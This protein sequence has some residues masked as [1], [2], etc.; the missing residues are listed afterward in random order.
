MKKRTP[1]ILFAVLVMNLALCR[2]MMGGLPEM[3]PVELDQE[4]IDKEWDELAAQW[5]CPEWFKD[6]KL[7]LWLH[8]GP[9]SV[10]E[11]GGGWFALHMYQSKNA[12]AFGAKAFPYFREKFGPQWKY[13]YKDV[14]NAWKAEK[15][16][17]DAIAERFKE[18]GAKYIAII[19][20]H[21]DHFDN[22]DS[23]YH[24]WNSVKVGP[25]R[26]IVGELK[27]AAD[28]HGLR[29]GLTCHDDR[30]PGFLGGSRRSEMVN[31]EKKLYDGHLTVEDGKG[32]WWE[33]LDPQNLY[34]GPGWT[35][36]KRMQHFVVRHEELLDK[37]EPDLF[38][39]DKGNFSP[40]LAGKKVAAYFYR[41][42]LERNGKI[43]AVM[44]LKSHKP[45]IVRDMEKHVASTTI[46]DYYWQIDTTYGA[47]F[48]KTDRE[49]E[50]SPET[51]IQMLVD[52]ISKNG[53]L[54][55]NVPQWPDG[56]FPEEC[57]E[58]L[59]EL[60]AWMKVN[61]SAVYGT[62]YWEVYRDGPTSFRASNRA[63]KKTDEQYASDEVR[64][65]KKDKTLY[66]FL[67]NPQ[68]GP[69][70]MKALGLKHAITKPGKVTAVSIVGGEAVEFS[71]NDEALE[72][73]VPEKRP[74][75]FVTALKI[76]GAIR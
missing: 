47:W 44:N 40:G 55:L 25:K 63:R 11:V 48:W 3:P 18:A 74:S 57:E 10:P 49:P 72:L 29:F 35:V 39:Y 68:A 50:H 1:A 52:V 21:H 6:A 53:N 13:G 22:W 24:E 17:A 65:V 73:T 56:T 58:L 27:K 67:M 41:K 32:K 76:E 28:K 43:D 59:D 36:E 51:V 2:T 54:L 23:T 9:C 60:T 71:Q 14:C 26:D 62:R 75:K 42:N 19:S 69:L 61:S 7:G 12:P 20:S 16:D 15:Y 8:W 5:E 30:W 46:K 34:G 38:Y 37:Y 4:K 33:G 70:K 31:G 45:G 66:A 64:F